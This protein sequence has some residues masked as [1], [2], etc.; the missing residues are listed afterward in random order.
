M[1]T[2]AKKEKKAC[3][4]LDKWFLDPE[5]SDV[6]KSNHSKNTKVSLH[7][8]LCDKSVSIE[9]QGKLDLQRY[10]RGKSHVNLLNAKRKQGP[11]NT[12]FLPQGSNIEKQASIAEVKVVGFLAEHNLPFA[13]ADHLGPLFKS[14]F[15]DSKIAKAY[16]CGKTKAS[17]ILNRAIALDL[18]SILIE[19]IKTSCYSIAID[20]S[21]D[22]GLQKM[23]PVTV[24]LFNIN[25]HKVVTK[26]Y[27]TCPSTSCSK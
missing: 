16:S 15:P 5:I 1:A 14:I 2:P 26:F 19:Q 7:C 13:T 8:L 24:R 25:Q 21:N 10:C 6:F 20:G 23:N 17:C 27:G 3:K 22:Q 4:I 12:H 9:H 11:I 18:Q